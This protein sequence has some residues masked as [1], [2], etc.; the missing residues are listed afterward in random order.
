MFDLAS[1][2]RLLHAV[3]TIAAIIGLGLAI[4]GPVKGTN[5]TVLDA[6]RHFGGCEHLLT[7]LCEFK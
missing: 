3:S 4:G 7:I 1:L 6:G 5:S 2:D